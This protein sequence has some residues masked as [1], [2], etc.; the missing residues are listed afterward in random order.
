MQTSYFDI[1][2]KDDTF[3]GTVVGDAGMDR[4]CWDKD[5]RTF[6]NRVFLLIYG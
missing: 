4:A 1:H 3:V 6:K 5:S 2:V